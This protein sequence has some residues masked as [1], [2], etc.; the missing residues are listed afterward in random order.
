MCQV[1]PLYRSKYLAPIRRCALEGRP[2]VLPIIGRIG[3]DVRIPPLAHT[4]SK[5]PGMTRLFL[6]TVIWPRPPTPI[7]TAV[8]PGPSRWSDRLTAW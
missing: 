1:P 4:P 7:T 2:G 6:S 5:T 3:S 8:E